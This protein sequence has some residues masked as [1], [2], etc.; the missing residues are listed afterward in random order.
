ML[1]S[2]NYVAK[3]ES[4]CYVWILMQGLNYTTMYSIARNWNINNG[5]FKTKIIPCISAT[6]SMHLTASSCGCLFVTSSDSSA[7][8]PP[9]NARMQF[10]AESHN[11]CKTYLR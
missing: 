1:L 7:Q 8:A 9:S 2:L 11:A 5:W 3:S 10:S 6:F 4:C